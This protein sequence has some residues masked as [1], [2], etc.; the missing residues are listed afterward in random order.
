MNLNDAFLRLIHKN[1]VDNKSDINTTLDGINSK[2]SSSYYDDDDSCHYI[3]SGSMGRGTSIRKESDI[4]VDFILPKDVYD[5]FNARHGNIQ[6]QL[7]SEVKDKL[8]DKY[9]RSDLNGDGQVV[10]IHFN[11]YL[12]EVLPCFKL[13]EFSDE[14]THPDS[15]DCGTGSGSWQRTNPKLQIQM[16]ND[17]CS[18]FRQF[19]EVCQIV[20]CWKRSQNVKLKG[21]LIDTFVYNCFQ[22]RKEYFYKDDDSAAYFGMIKEFFTYLSGIS[23]YTK[24]IFDFSYHDYINIGDLSFIKKSKKALKKMNES[25]PETLWDNLQGLFGYGFPDYP[26]TNKFTYTEEFIDDMFPV[27]ITNHLEIECTI[28]QDGFRDEP[29]WMFLEKYNWLPH[30]KTLWFSIKST[31]VIPPYDI[32]WK[33][34]NVG[35]EAQRRDCIRGQIIKGGAK[36]KETADFYGPH[37][38]DCYIVKNNV[39]VA[40]DT[41][42][43][44]IQK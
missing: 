1:Q 29:L 33:V 15:H 24:S 12:V 30:N 21:I 14:L 31:D 20:R 13:S 18:S 22:G 7:L 26:T 32:Y 36:K 43:V 11:D 38:V 8:S 19:K 37:F 42:S 23:E 27:C 16:A 3:L 6:S 44:P 10:D 28:S 39:C 5:R 9:P 2:I 41:I 34:R 17:F 35:E 40:K 25:D 4:D